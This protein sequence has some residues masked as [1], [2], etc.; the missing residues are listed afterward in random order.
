MPEVRLL[1]AW[2]GEPI[3]SACRNSEERPGNVGATYEQTTNSASERD[4]QDAREFRRGALKNDG[5]S[6]S[7]IALY[8][9]DA[10]LT[11]SMQTST[12]RISP[13][14]LLLCLPLREG[15]FPL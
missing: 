13:A 7:E 8:R 3:P 14:R 6:D 15:P 10:M 1:L 5:K 11:M 9:L 12:W 2:P 4:V